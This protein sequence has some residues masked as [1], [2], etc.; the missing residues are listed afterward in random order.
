MELDRAT[1]NEV[2]LVL[3]LMVREQQK[4]SRETIIK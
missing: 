2:F 4:V 1:D 3:E